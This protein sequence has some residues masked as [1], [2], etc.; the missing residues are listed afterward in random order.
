MNGQTEYINRS[1][2]RITPPKMSKSN[3]Y[4]CYGY[5][6]P[7]AYEAVSLKNG[8]VKFVPGAHNP[9]T[10]AESSLHKASNLYIENLKKIE[11]M[12]L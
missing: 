11:E 10:W 5:K 7:E 12:N 2:A 8:K 6:L 9:L 4:S 3:G 1:Y